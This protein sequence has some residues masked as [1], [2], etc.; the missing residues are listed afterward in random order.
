[1]ASNNGEWVTVNRKKPMKEK[2]D[3]N[4]TFVVEKKKREPTAMDQ[5]IKSEKKPKV[6]YDRILMSDNSKETPKENGKANGT[7]EKSKKPKL[8]KSGQPPPPK[9]RF[10]SDKSF[11][12]D[13]KKITVNDIRSM[14]TESKTHFPDSK[15]LW[16]KDIAVYI[17]TLIPYEVTDP[18]FT[19]KPENYPMCLLK[20]EVV[21]EIKD[22]FDECTSPTLQLFH[23]FCIETVVRC[24]SKLVLPTAGYLAV[25]Q[26]LAQSNPEIASNNVQRL[27]DARTSYK[28]KHP[29]GLTLMWIALQSARND[30]DNGLRLWYD[31]IYPLLPSRAFTD[32]SI[33][34]IEVILESIKNSKNYKN[35]QISK[36]LFFE[37]FDFILGCHGLSKLNSQRL[38]KVLESL[39]HIFI[40]KNE[41]NLEEFFLQLLTRQEGKYSTNYLQEVMSCIKQCV[42]LSPSLMAQICRDHPDQLVRIAKTLES[43]SHDGFLEK[44]PKEVFRETLLHL[45]N[46]TKDPSK[47]VNAIHLKQLAGNLDRLGVSFV[48]FPH[49]SF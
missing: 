45:R 16:L 36:R 21:Q 33:T 49:F 34:C 30:L 44:I 48:H 28:S 32:Y 47:K 1:M 10:T 15:S 23:E 6:N 29:I 38:K 7:V 2:P 4:A 46:A 20:K 19:G 14:L 22:L 9:K 5:F 26:I 3:P 37:L 13:V 43:F 25:I 31:V 18:I 40:Q 39:E 24:M 35:V 12:N 17:N 27:V 42:S 41:D 11:E 8:H